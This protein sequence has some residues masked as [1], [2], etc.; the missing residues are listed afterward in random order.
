MFVALVAFGGS[1]RCF[2]ILIFVSLASLSIMIHDLDFCQL[3]PLVQ[4][5]SHDDYNGER[6][7]LISPLFFFLILKGM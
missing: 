5:P 1:V 3:S 7:S 6:V 4:H 2:A